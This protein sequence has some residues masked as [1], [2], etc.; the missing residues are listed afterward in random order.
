MAIISGSLLLDILAVIVTLFIGLYTY[1][2]WAYKYW[3][4]KGIPYVTP[5]FPFGTK[6]LF[7]DPPQSFS[8]VCKK[9]YNEYKA[10]G[11]KHVGIYLFASPIY[12][13]LDLE[14]IRNIISKD[15]DHFVDRGAYFNDRNDPLSEHIFN[16]EGARWRNLRAKLT[17]TFTSGKMKMMFPTLVECGSHMKDAI[18]IMCLQKCPVDIKEVLARFTTDIIGSCAFGID[19]NCFSDPNS[20]FRKY[21]KRAFDLTKIETFKLFIG[22]S[23][24]SFA[25]KIG[26]KV[27]PDEVIEF[28]LNVIE[29]TLKYREDNNV[30]RKDFFQLLMEIKDSVKDENGKGIGLTKNEFA[31]QAFVFFAAGYE[32]SSTAMTF[33]LFELTQN[34]EIQQKVRNEINEVL[35]KHNGEITYDAIMEMKYMGQVIDEALRKYPPVTGLSRKCIK[36]YKLPD[37]DITISKGTSVLIPVLGLHQDPEYFPDPEVFNPDRFSEENKSSIKPY[38]YLPFGEGPRACIGLRFGLMQIRM[39]LTLLLKDYKITLNEKTKVPLKMDP[40]A[41]VYTVEGDVWL[42]VEK[43]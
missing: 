33:C 20:N 17:P 40:F 11:Y 9:Y 22:F 43:I 13:V 18:D 32:T 1:F 2:Q 26:V 30:I 16:I 10:K 23:A 27:T 19:C 21:G 28:F 6:D 41:F 12:L 34:L 29:E 8:D 24:P 25:R 14:Y 31:A 37:T 42:N 5:S 39:G 7:A 36:D 38:S 3:E 35:K 4:R 15:F